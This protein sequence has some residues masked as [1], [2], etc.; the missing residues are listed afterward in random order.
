MDPST[1]LFVPGQ[2]PLWKGVG[3]YI[4]TV[5]TAYQALVKSGG[6][7]KRGSFPGF[8]QHRFGYITKANL[9]KITD[10]QVILVDCR[11][12]GEYDSQKLGNA[13]NIPMEDK[14]KTVEELSKNMPEI[15]PFEKGL[16]EGSA[17]VVFYC[18]AGNTRSPSAAAWYFMQHWGKYY[19]AILEGGIG[20]EPNGSLPGK[21]QASSGGSSS[22]GS[23]SG[24]SLSPKK[25]L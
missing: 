2:A 1:L 20:A 23:S 7:D 16:E 10:R 19:V 18:T 5:T 13:F 12:V 17:L 25:K 21:E 11:S 24:G 9:V 22:G 14:N 4:G 3:K 8:L 6:Q 15:M